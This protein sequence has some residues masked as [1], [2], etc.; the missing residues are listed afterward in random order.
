MRPLRREKY[1]RC[2]DET[3][4][5]FCCERVSHNILRDKNMTD[6]KF[7]CHVKTVRFRVRVINF[8]LCR[9]LALHY[10]CNKQTASGRRAQK[11]EDNLNQW[12]LVRLT[13]VP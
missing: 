5:S 2:T 12:R 7:L 13:D 11:T 4:F 10:F 9:G 1:R 8:G 3:G 6:P